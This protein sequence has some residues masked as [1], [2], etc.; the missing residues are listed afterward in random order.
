MRIMIQYLGTSIANFKAVKVAPGANVALLSSK[1]ISIGLGAYSITN[2][3]WDADAIVAS[4]TAVSNALLNEITA[5]AN[6]DDSI[7]FTQN[8][9]GKDFELTVLVDGDPLQVSTYQLITFSPAPSGGT[10]TLSDGTLTTGAI[11]WDATPATVVTNIQNAINALAGYTAGDVVVTTLSATTYQLDFSAGRFAGLPVTLWTFNGSSLTGGNAGITVTTTQQGSAGV[12]AI[13]ELSFPVTGDLSGK[14]VQKITL[15]GTIL[16]GATWTL[17]LDEGATFTKP[18]QI[19]ATAKQVQIAI[20]ETFALTPEDIVVFGP[21]GGPFLVYWLDE[22]N[23]SLI[24]VVVDNTGSSGETIADTVLVDEGT[25]PASGSISHGFEVQVVE[26]ALSGIF[27]FTMDVPQGAT[28]LSATLSGIT[29]NSPISAGAGTLLVG[30]DVADDPVF[31]ANGADATAA[32]LGSTTSSPTIVTGS[33]EAFSFDIRATLQQYVNTANYDAEQNINVH[34]RAPSSGQAFYM[35]SATLAVVYESTETSDGSAAVTLITDGTTVSQEITGGTFN[36]TIEGPVTLN[37]DG[38]DFD[39]TAAE[40]VAAINAAAGSTIVSGSG[41]PLPGTVVELTFSGDFEKAPVTI[42]ASSSF[43]GTFDGAIAQTVIRSATA[44]AEALNVWDMTICPGQGTLAVDPAL[45]GVHNYFVISIIEPTE[46]LDDVTVYDTQTAV[47]ASQKKIYVRLYDINAMRIQ[48]A[49]NEAYAADVCRV[50]RVTHSHEWRRI[51]QPTVVSTGFDFAQPFYCWYYRDVYR[52]TFINRFAAAT[53]ITALSVAPAPVS[54]ENATLTGPDAWMVNSQTLP[55]TSL[56]YDLSNEAGRTYQGFV[57]MAAEAEPLHI[58]SAERCTEDVS[59]LLSFRYK[60]A[61]QYGSSPQ[62]ALTAP[63]DYSGITTQLVG[64]SINFRWVKVVKTNAAETSTELASGATLA[65]SADLPWDATNEQITAAIESLDAA[66]VG[67]VQVTG[68]LLNSWKPEGY[69]DL[70]DSDEDYDDLLITFTN[71]LAYLPLNEQWYELRMGVVA[72]SYVGES[73]SYNRKITN[74]SE[75]FSVPLPPFKNQRIRYTM[76]GDS[77][78]IISY[79]GDSVSLA[80]AATISAIEAAFNQLLGSFTSAALPAAYTKSAKVYGVPFS[81]GSWEVELTGF[82]FQQ[83]AMPAGLLVGTDGLALI[84]V[85]T[86][87]VAPVNETE[88]LVITGTPFSGSY[89]ITGTPGTTGSLAYNASAGTI[90]TAIRLLAGYGS[91]TV[92]GSWP[93]FLVT[94][95]SSLGNVTQLTTTPALN[96]AAATIATTQQGGPD[97]QLAISDIIPGRGPAYY[98]VAENYSPQTVPGSGDTLVYDNAT[99]AVNF[100]LDQTSIIKVASLSTYFFRHQRNRKV[101][102]DG[103][104][105]RFLTT[106]TAPG[107]LT[108]GN[109]YYIVGAADNYQFQMS[110]TLDGAAIAITSVGTGVHSLQVESVEVQVFNRYSGGTIGLPI[111]RSNNMLEYLEQYLTIPG[112]NVTF[113]FTADEGDGISMFKGDT[114]DLESH[115][116][117]NQTGQPSGNIPAIFLLFNNALSTLEMFDGQVGIAFYTGETS[118]LDSVTEH[119]GELTMCNTTVDTLSAGSDATQSLRACTINET[120]NI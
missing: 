37:V 2:V 80:Q 90:Q 31:P 110:A 117:V 56:P 78:F 10:F 4:W 55:V 71:Q 64:Y 32:T 74:L 63:T 100:G 89:T 51:I 50:V 14:E 75:L 62:D 114:G 102:C 16:T 46:Q 36:L 92:T 48:R 5:V 116:I 85:T 25:Y 24:E 115:I 39:S 113:G 98:D 118:L 86:A 6:E 87:G 45:D 68:S 47:A 7:T 81:Q 96:N 20:E 60:L 19:Y 8:N 119:D 88:T 43:S 42:T 58:F 94:F 70:D 49:I 65:V 23:H 105:V 77:S 73:N 72:A 82:G 30:I 120:V 91:V 109:E 54:A 35:A 112:M 18:L 29:A 107:G 44:P 108:D 53:T 101:F 27:Q 13:V 95:P 52:I 21:A 104:K 76:T 33:D 57:A 99:T 38:L 9:S 40:V 106:G 22:T 41:G 3:G 28:I 17:S 103:Q 26:G 15:S 1:T 67:N 84:D 12:D 61:A 79:D 11:S 83:T 59:N 93:S 111:R 66:F 34:V 69:T 97:S